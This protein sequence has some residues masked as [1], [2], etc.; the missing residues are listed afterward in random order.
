MVAETQWNRIRRSYRQLKSTEAT[1]EEF[2]MAAY[3]HVDW[4]ADY[5]T[6]SH[7]STR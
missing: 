3:K 1:V 7:E 4:V 2:R 5:L 6:E